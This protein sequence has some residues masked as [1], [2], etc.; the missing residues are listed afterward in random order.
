MR[1]EKWP[2]LQSDKWVIGL[3]ACLPLVVAIVL[4]EIVALMVD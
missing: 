3:A 2:E 1:T 4:V